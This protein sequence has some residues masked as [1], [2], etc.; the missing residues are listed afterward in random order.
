MNPRS[1]TTPAPRRERH[2]RHANP[3]SIRHEVPPLDQL[4]TF[5][6][7]APLALDIGF[8]EGGFLLELARRHPEWNVL[9]L[10]IREH[11]VRQLDEDARQAGLANA[12]AVLANANINLGH[13]V[14]ARSVA[15]IAINHPDPWYKKRHKKRRVVNDALVATLVDKLAPGAE[16]HSM[17]DYEPIAREILTVLSACPTLE[18]LDGAGQ[19]ATATTTGIVTEREVK[20]TARGE[21][22][23]RMRFRRRGPA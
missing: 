18:N 15:F 21:P 10:E 9:G 23:W 8:G 17:S 6:R 11:L 4:A 5:G 20:H 7:A 2:R 3:F 16:L 12:R 22:I 14:P 1:E 13:L 19:F